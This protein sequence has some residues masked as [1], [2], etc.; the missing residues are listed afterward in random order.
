[1][2]ATL[3]KIFKKAPGSEMEKFLNGA[4]SEREAL[5][6]LKE[7]RK[8]DEDR[9][10]RANVRLKEI[11]DAEQ[12]MMDEGKADGIASSKKMHLVRMI[13]QGRDEQKDLLHKVEKIYGPRLKAVATHIQSLE[14]IIEVQGEV[15]P[16]SD[17]VEEMAIKAKNMMEDLDSTFE[18]VKGI[19]STSAEVG[20][21]PEDQAI[22][23]EMNTLAEEDRLKKHEEETK[24]A[25][26]EKEKERKRKEKEAE[27]KSVSKD[28]RPEKR[29]KVAYIDEEES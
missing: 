25:E 1:M 21:D 10:D 22:V 29:Q 7:A 5:L 8:R 28:K 4:K 17:S 24:K 13:K 2:I 16:S 11:A 18:L 9:R 23:E 15:T 20:V 27:K 3:K 12:K 14:T 19:N 26:K 6:L